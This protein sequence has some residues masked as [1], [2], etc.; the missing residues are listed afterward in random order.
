MPAIDPL[1]S[2]AEVAEHKEIGVT[3]S[4]SVQVE[5]S[6]TRAPFSEYAIADQVLKD[7]EAY[8]SLAAY[9]ANTL[10][11]DID[12]LDGITAGSDSNSVAVIKGQLVRLQEGFQ[13]VSEAI[14]KEAVLTREAAV[15]VGQIISGLREGYAAW[16]SE[17]KDLAEGLQK[18][19]SVMLGTVALYMFCDVPGFLAACISTAL[20][21]NERLS[22]ILHGHKEKNN[23]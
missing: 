6:V 11:R 15:K 3:S 5:T 23:D 8:R 22:D 9:I 2:V 19:A 16:H 13:E 20:V 1:L 18:L 4:T 12:R 17:H 7:P 21:N 14:P 10:Q